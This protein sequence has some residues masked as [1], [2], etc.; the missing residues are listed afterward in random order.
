MIWNDLQCGPCPALWKPSPWYCC[1][2]QPQLLH[3]S[4]CH[5]GS[6]ASP[7]MSPRCFSSPLHQT[8]VTPSQVTRRQSSQTEMMM[9]SVKCARKLSESSQMFALWGELRAI[10]QYKM[11]STHFYLV[12]CRIKLE[13]FDLLPPDPGD[14]CKNDRFTIL[15]EGDQVQNQGESEN[16]N[17]ARS[18]CGARPGTQGD[19]T[20]N[21]TSLVTITDN[22]T[23]LCSHCPCSETWA[24]LHHY[25]VS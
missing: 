6:T 15:V 18:L 25:E 5:P 17:T 19:M 7:L 3:S 22:N 24:H 20:Q 9:L 10:N 11:L 14:D 13:E 1:S 8:P 4:W 16:G 12:N 21:M 23:L 2:K